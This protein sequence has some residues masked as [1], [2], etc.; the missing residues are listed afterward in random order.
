MNTC[1]TVSVVVS[2]IGFGWCLLN[3]SVVEFVCLSIGWLAGHVLLRCSLW[4]DI[5]DILYCGKRRGSKELTSTEGHEDIFT[6]LYVC[7]SPNL[8][9][10]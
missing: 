1:P 6:C 9:M 3:V 10:L 7:M 5:L 8:T 4:F 2:V